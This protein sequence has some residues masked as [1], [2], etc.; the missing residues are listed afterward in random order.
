MSAKNRFLIGYLLFGGLNLSEAASRDYRSKEFLTAVT[1]GQSLEAVTRQLAR[2]AD[3]NYFGKLGATKDIY[4]W[5][6]T[7]LHWAA[8]HNRTEL[9]DLLLARGA[10]KAIQDSNTK[11]AFRYAQYK[12]LKRKLKFVPMP[13]NLAEGLGF[14]RHINIFAHMPMGW[15]MGDISPSAQAK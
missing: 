14:G 10:D 8:K 4:E 5:H 15:D 9:A 11:E 2:G 13:K 1:A 7:A 6:G 3:V 12:K